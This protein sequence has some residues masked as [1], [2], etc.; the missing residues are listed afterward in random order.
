[1]KKHL[2][3]LAA[4]GL[5][6]G[7]AIAHAEG[8]PDRPI[9]IVVPFPPGGSVDSVARL[10]A[11]ELA[12]S[13]GKTVVV[14]N[15][16]GGAGGVVGTTAVANAKP[17]G[18][19]LILDAS[20]HVVT[21]LLNK[22]V[23][24]DVKTDFTNIGMVAAG[25]L[26]VSTPTNTPANTLAE[27]F[28]AYKADPTKYNIATSGYGSAGHLA[29]EYLIRSAGVDAQVVAY[30]GA[31]P[32]LNDLI[33]GQ[34][35][36]MADPMASSLPHV[37]GGKLKALAVTSLERSPLAPDVPTVGESGMEPFEM[38]SWYGLW[39]PKDLDPEAAAYLT[40]AVET[41]VKSD[42]YKTRIE[43]MGFEPVYKS[44]DELKT[45]ISDEMAKY[46]KIIKDANIK[47]N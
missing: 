12:K 18:Y 20:I 19:T 46:E 7:P 47:V 9:T 11:D 25:P 3:A 39:A 14:D 45:Y 44:P 1:M 38:L 27:F 28:E 37:K 15:K 42:S 6:A 24:Y 5:L 2:I 40:K 35:Q 29:V 41:V 30:K 31:G 16:A 36:L 8:F 26:L 22:N 43:A 34:V 4:A 21:P 23:P 32:A 13:T 33:G 17:D 10:V